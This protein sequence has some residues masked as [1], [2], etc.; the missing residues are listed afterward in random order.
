M[1]KFHWF[2][3]SVLG[4]AAVGLTLAA[5][6]AKADGSKTAASAW[7]HKSVAQQ[8]RTIEANR[9]K[10]PLL[11]ETDARKMGETS[12]A[13]DDQLDTMMDSMKSMVARAQELNQ[14]MV[15]MMKETPGS[16]GEYEATVQ[17]MA[18]TMG[19]MAQLMQQTEQRYSQMLQNRGIMNDPQMRSDLDYLRHQSDA[20]GSQMD[21][22]MQAIEKLGHEIEENSPAAKANPV[23][24]QYP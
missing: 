20:I 22:Q 1:K 5:A 17:R 3:V 11:Y 14:S 19:A 21:R 2:L 18:E 13:R 24:E 7:S 16:S 10:D 12:T 4:V 15:K 9:A 23:N 6:Q 8:E